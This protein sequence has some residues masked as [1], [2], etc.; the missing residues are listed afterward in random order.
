MPLHA[1]SV[2]NSGL[3]LVPILGPSEFHL[4]TPSLLEKQLLKTETQWVQSKCRCP[5]QRFKQYWGNTS[6]TMER[7]IQEDPHTDYKCLDPSLSFTLQ[8]LPA[9]Q[10]HL[11]VVVENEREGE[12][13]WES[14]CPVRSV[15]WFK[16]RFPGAP[17]AAVYG[18]LDASP[19]LWSR[20]PSAE[21]YQ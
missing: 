19:C 4:H 7:A 14:V 10:H 12:T 1:W 6:S 8:E 11:L 5:P 21:T 16:R 18:S 3:K 13:S 17:C 20:R 2:I 9:H 15:G